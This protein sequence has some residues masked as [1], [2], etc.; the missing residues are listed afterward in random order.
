M[1][2]I[3]NEAKEMENSPVQL[4]EKEIEVKEIEQDKPLQIQKSN[5]KRKKGRCERK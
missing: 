3:K 4:L 5:T 2:E 1:E